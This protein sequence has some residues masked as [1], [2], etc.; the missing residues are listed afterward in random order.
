MSPIDRSRNLFSPASPTQAQTSGAALKNPLGS[1]VDA[2]KQGLADIPRF[3]KMGAD[4]FEASHLREVQRLFGGDAKPDRMSDGKFIAP[5]CTAS[6][7]ATSTPSAT[8]CWTPC[9]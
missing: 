2:A 7:T 4:V 8:T 9:T 1:V 6:P 5:S 3:V